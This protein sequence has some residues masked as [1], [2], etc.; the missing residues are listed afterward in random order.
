[1]D[2]RTYSC[3]LKPG[4][5]EILEVAASLPPEDSAL[6]SGLVLEA[7]DSPVDGALVLLLDQETGNMISHTLSD[8]QGRF[9]LGPLEPDRL[10]TLRVQ[11]HGSRVRTVELHL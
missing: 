10:Y 7:P 5:G 2:M 9:W 4:A 6:I 3:Y 1:M 8:D 11:K